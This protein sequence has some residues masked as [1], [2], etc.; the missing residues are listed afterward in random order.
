MTAINL[1]IFK[2]VNNLLN[3]CRKITYFN[4]RRILTINFFQSFEKIEDL[5][6]QQTPSEPTIFFKR[7]FLKYILL[8]I[9][10]A[11]EGAHAHICR[12]QMCLQALEGALAHIYQ[13]QMS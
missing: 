3:S 7:I 10:K 4:F 2:F 5:T 1:V 9:I 13:K 11:T 8:I 12:K 6:F